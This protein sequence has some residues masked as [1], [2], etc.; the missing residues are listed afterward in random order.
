MWKI[1]TDTHNIN[2]LPNVYAG[3][4]CS[5]VQLQLNPQVNVLCVF[6]RFDVVTYCRYTFTLF[7]FLI[8]PFSHS[9]KTV[10]HYTDEMSSGI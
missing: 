5:Y 8:L 1:E 6:F 3:K 2:T 7:L 10:M 9:H 4:C